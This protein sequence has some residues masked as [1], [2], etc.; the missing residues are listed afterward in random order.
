MFISVNNSFGFDKAGVPLSKI[1]L[2][3]SFRI[4]HKS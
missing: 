3:E 2:F 1:T 4:G